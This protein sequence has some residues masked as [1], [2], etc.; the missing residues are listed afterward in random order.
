[1]VAIKVMVDRALHDWNSRVAFFRSRWLRKYPHVDISMQPEPPAPDIDQK[2]LI[3][4]L[5]AA[6]CDIIIRAEFVEA[7]FDLFWSNVK[8]ATM[9]F[10]SRPPYLAPP[11]TLG[12]GLSNQTFVPRGNATDA[13][14]I[15][16]YGDAA[17]FVIL[18]LD[19]PSPLDRMSVF[20]IIMSAL[21]YVAVRSATAIGADSFQVGPMPGRNVKV[22]VTGQH[23]PDLPRTGPRY[24]EYRYVVEALRAVPEWMLDRDGFEDVFVGIYV[25]NVL[26]GVGFVHAKDDDGVASAGL[27]PLDLPNTQ[28]ST[29]YFCRRCLVLGSSQWLDERD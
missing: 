16:A 15:S 22:E 29:S 3:W 18:P 7:Y 13:A 10:R 28:A 8:V 23:R 6:Q 12:A 17:H 5:D 1:M 4:G 24:L 9:H 26:V 20:T 2:V 14:T 21:R 25:R 11:L 27:L 19:D